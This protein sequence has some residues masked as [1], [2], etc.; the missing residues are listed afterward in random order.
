MNPQRRAFLTAFVPGVVAVGAGLLAAAPVVARTSQGAS[1]P[2]QQATV[3][4]SSASDRPLLPPAAVQPTNAQLRQN[5][6]DIRK[7][8]D[9]LFSL[10][11]DLKNLADKNDAATELSVNLL[12]KT[13]EIEKLAKK[14]R[15][16]A[17]S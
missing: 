7:D 3:P 15:D 9:Q 14:I 8:V 11:Q 13:E 12:Q 2:Q 16:L 6:R 5:Q 10:A 17:R 4:P 1:R